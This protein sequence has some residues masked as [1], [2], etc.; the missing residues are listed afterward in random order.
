MNHLT[1]QPS[2]KISLWKLIGI[3]CLC[4]FS[5][6][7]NAAHYYPQ[8][9]HPENSLGDLY[10][11]RNTLKSRGFEIS[12]FYAAT[13]Q[14]IA[15]GGLQRDN[16]YAGLFNVGLQSD[17]ETLLH[18]PGASFYVS[19]SWASGGSLLR[20]VGNLFSVST[21][22]SGQSLRLYELWYNQ[23]LYHQQLELRIGRLSPAN[24][25]AILPVFEDYIS[26]A[27]NAV[28]G[29]FSI[30]SLNF[31]ADPVAQWAARAQFKLNEHLTA[32]IGAYNG[33]PM[34]IGEN[35]KHGLDF[36]FRPAHGLLS[37]AEMEY[38]WSQLHS[39]S[40]PGVFKIGGYYD[41]SQFPVVS[42]PMQ[43]ST[44]NGLFYA[45]LQQK[46]FTPDQSDRG[47]TGWS[48]Y[49]YAP[50]QT[51][52][53]LPQSVSGGLNYTGLLPSR[54]KDKLIFGVLSAFFGKFAANSSNET[55]TEFA[56]L[57]QVTPAIVIQPDIQYIIH[58]N[59]QSHPQNAFVLGGLLAVE[60]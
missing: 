14:T 49:T 42:N 41:S 28:L 31:N 52:S 58:P 18:V 19:G 5:L 50:H 24:D 15:A 23:S 39:Y 46:L 7:A 55:D 44:K 47:L 48:G 20:P 59:G 3:F 2:L 45:L 33:D 34:N 4:V 26:A 40:L 54:P 30:N 32:R 16:A 12:G 27:F 9:H 11:I 29:V 8:R 57:I 60:F 38:Q 1:H 13:W 6:T 35:N 10:G 22:F 17:L 21:V 51:I 25:F 53:L 43:R 56:Y 37:I 36:R